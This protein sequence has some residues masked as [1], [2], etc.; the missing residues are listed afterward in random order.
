MSIRMLP[1]WLGLLC[2]AF[3]VQPLLAHD[4]PTFSCSTRDTEAEWIPEATT[5]R[6]DLN[7]D[8]T[9]LTQQEIDEL[10]EIT[11]WVNVHFIGPVG[12]NFEPGTGVD[13]NAYAQNMINKANEYLSD[14]KP[15]P[16]HTADF[17]GDSKYR[18]RLFSDPNNSADLHGGIWYWTSVPTFYPYGDNVLNIIMRDIGT[19]GSFD[20]GGSAC[21]LNTCDKIFLNDAYDNA[22]NGGS[23]NW[24]NYARITLHETGHV[25]GLCHSFYCGNPCDG[26]GLDVAAECSINSCYSSCGQSPGTFCDNWNSGSSNMM[27]YNPKNW[28]LTPCQ[29]AAVYTRLATTS[30]AYVQRC[31]IVDQFPEMAGFENDFNGWNHSPCDD[32]SWQR[33]SG[34][35][36][37]FGT[38]PSNAAQGSYYAYIEATNNYNQSATLT[39]PCIVIDEPDYQLSFQYHMY[40]FGGSGS[41]G[42]LLVDISYDECQTW[43]TIWAKI[44]GQGPDWQG[45]TLSIPYTEGEAFNLRFRGTVKSSHL[46]DIAI[47]AVRISACEPPAIP[48]T[49][50][51]TFNEDCSST[52]SIA[53]VTGASSY[54]WSLQSAPNYV[55]LIENGTTQATAFFTSAPSPTAII[56]LCV[57]AYNACDAGDL[58]CQ[59]FELGCETIRRDGSSSPL[60]NRDQTLDLFPN[61]ARDHVT[62]QLNARIQNAQGRIFDTKGQEWRRFIWTGQSL[63][64]D[65][66]ELPS[67]IYFVK[68]NTADGLLTKK[69]VVQ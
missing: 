8:L 52:F 29:W 36:P 31:E 42:N 3:F 61:P 32:F 59:W 65:I 48:G 47:D 21:G 54:D 55:G 19:A 35:T 38:G 22:A 67:G 57:Q 45:A 13:G 6:T 28:S 2:Q 27:G 43:N 23:W 44:G 53:P 11:I 33:N 12:A 64:V 68:F 63:E 62:I 14:M 34:P 51:Q 69:L 18:L 10:P 66:S 56:N 60:E 50:T 15:S 1:L 41:M 37:S 20:F 49:I 9:N 7:C 30:A 16:T 17:L 25:F 46:G 40:T 26:D 39:S 4:P 5:A 58:K 24:W